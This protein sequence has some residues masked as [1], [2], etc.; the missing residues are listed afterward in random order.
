MRS[1]KQRFTIPQISRPAYPSISYN[2]VY[3]IPDRLYKSACISSNTRRQKEKK[4]LKSPVPIYI[5]SCTPHQVRSTHSTPEIPLPLLPPTTMPAPMLLPRRPLRDIVILAPTDSL[6]DLVDENRLPAS[7]RPNA[8][9][10]SAGALSDRPL[11]VFGRGPRALALDDFAASV[12]DRVAR[13]S[14][15]VGAVVGRWR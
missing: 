13:S 15:A 1:T 2:M 7:R 4:Q 9:V 5:S 8:D 14:A 3:T 10:S 6:L 12:A 11:Q